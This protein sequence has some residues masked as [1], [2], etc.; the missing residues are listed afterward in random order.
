MTKTDN[1]DHGSPLGPLS[2]TSYELGPNDDVPDIIEFD[3][4][5]GAA[6]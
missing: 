2:H 5:M 4:V 1:P 3:D 6:H